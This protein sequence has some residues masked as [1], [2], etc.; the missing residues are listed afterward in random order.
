[1]ATTIATMT[2][3]SKD[4]VSNAMSLSSTSALY[5][6]N[7]TA[8]G[9]TQVKSGRVNVYVTGASFDLIPALAS[10]E[11]SATNSYVYIA[12]KNTDAANYVTISIFNEVIGR[13][14]AGDW[15]FV[16]YE[17]NDP[18]ADNGSDNDIEVEALVGGPQAIEWI[19][20]TESTATILDASGD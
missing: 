14:Y 15:M 3:S 1:M 13:L 5:N 19:M 9:L 2:L 12:N 10:E 7:T 4:I 18:E 20:F 17:Q 11:A 8:T 16:P 6:H